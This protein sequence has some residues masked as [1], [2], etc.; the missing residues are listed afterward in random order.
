MPELAVVSSAAAGLFMSASFGCCRPPTAPTAPD[1]RTPQTMSVLFA[2]V[3]Q[4]R[5][6]NIAH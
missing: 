1:I 4:A 6:R 5:V 2:C 3:A